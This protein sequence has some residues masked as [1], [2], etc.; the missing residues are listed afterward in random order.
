MLRH[1]DVTPPCAHPQ[2]L[3]RRYSA[4]KPHSAVHGPVADVPELLPA[5][6]QGLASDARPRAVSAHRKVCAES[7]VYVPVPVPVPVPAWEGLVWGLLC[8][9]IRP[10]LS[11]CSPTCSAPVVPQQICWIRHGVPVRSSPLC[12]TFVCLASLH[13]FLHLCPGPSTS[14]NDRRWKTTPKTPSLYCRERSCGVHLS[15]TV[16][17]RVPTVHLPMAS[18]TRCRGQ[19][20]RLKQKAGACPCPRAPSFPTSWY[21]VSPWRASAA[22]AAFNF[23]YVRVDTP[24]QLPAEQEAGVVEEEGQSSG[25]ESEDAA[26]DHMSTP[27]LESLLSTFARERHRR[28]ISSLPDNTLQVRV[29]TRDK[30][31][32][33]AL[34]LPLPHLYLLPLFLF[35]SQSHFLAKLHMDTG[36]ADAVASTDVR[37]CLVIV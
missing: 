14:R 30:S 35:P 13:V 16:R 10:P 22:H 6:A 31:A 7:Q 4:G 15:K 3:W 27:P 24:L 33:C 19:V 20:W 36:V 8:H 25:S 12:A 23:S 37:S 11:V 18:G 2:I 5:A 32:G 1:P 17:F 26:M 9:L 34:F 21:G 29:P 28:S